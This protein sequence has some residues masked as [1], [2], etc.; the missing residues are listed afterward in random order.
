MEL[1]QSSQPELASTITHDCTA[2]TVHVESQSV[3]AIFSQ[4]LD[5]NQPAYSSVGQ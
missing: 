2:F 3:R 4:G 1:A 5:V